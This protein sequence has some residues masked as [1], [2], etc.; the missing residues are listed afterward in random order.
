MPCWVQ[1]L[2][3]NP[4]HRRKIWLIRQIIDNSLLWKMLVMHLSLIDWLRGMS[5]RIWMG[6]P[7][8]LQRQ[9]WDIHV[10]HRL[11]GFHC[12]G[13]T[14]GFDAI[15]DNPLFFR[16]PIL[17]EVWNTHFPALKNGAADS[18]QRTP[19]LGVALSQ[20]K[21]FCLILQPPSKAGHIQWSI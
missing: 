20:R 14:C 5:Y 9:F 15:V 1:W 12:R 7:L 13:V 11:P 10:V 8:C 21:W 6:V 19:T 3:K 17:L 2:W 16:G 4:Y 18:S